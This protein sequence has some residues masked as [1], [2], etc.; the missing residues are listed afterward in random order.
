MTE[1]HVSDTERF[2]RSFDDTAWNFDLLGP[3]LWDPIGEATVEYTAPAR[4]ESVLDACCGTGA[5]AIPAG[6]RVG[7]AGHVDAVDLSAVLLK[8]LRRKAQEMPQI[9]THRAD[10]TVWERDGYDVV[11]CALGIFFLPDTT[12]GTEHLISRA[13]RGGRIGFTIWRRGAVEEA[14][15]H[16]QAALA[17][18]R[19]ADTKPKPKPSHLIERIN[20][21][22]AFRDWLRGLGLERA[23]VTES[24][25]RVP[26]TP[27]IAW[28]VITGSGYVSAINGLDQQQVARVRDAYLGSLA[29]AGVTELDATTLI[30]TGTRG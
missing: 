22:G 9:A 28:L 17:Q 21:A 29:D 4:G 25:L 24:A 12:A 3:H 16:L 18:V 8:Q 14:A 7:A 27:E 1:A 5:S 13:R 30:G 26:M 20:Q 11:Q 6:R 19:T 10:A 23:T 2:V 15:R